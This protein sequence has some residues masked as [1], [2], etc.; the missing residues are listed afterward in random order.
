M[1]D[2]ANNAPRTGGV[3]GKGFVPGKSG[4]PTGRPKGF[5]A[6]IREQT[7][8]GEE[9]AKFAIDILRGKKGAKLPD[10]LSAMT[11]LADRG[12]GKPLQSTEMTGEVKISLSWDDGKDDG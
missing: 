10:Q 2:V 7:N 8:D 5:A 11:W 4:N 3:T 9:L 12:W 1:S 6:F